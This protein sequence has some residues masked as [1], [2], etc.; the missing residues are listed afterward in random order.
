M[1]LAP[2]NMIPD[3][4]KKG[5]GMFGSILGG[6]AGAASALIPGVGLAAA[7]ALMGA[8]MAAG[9][10]LGET[11]DPSK[12]GSIG[13]PVPTMNTKK[14]ALNVMM[15]MP[16]VQLATMQNAKNLLKVSDNPQA[17]NYVGLIDSAQQKLRNQLGDQSSIKLV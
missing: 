15:K 7:P 17:G 8:G 14:P 16:E 1:A 3:P 9:G 4:P 12:A 2:V 13:T 5:G 6:L 10:L 11:A